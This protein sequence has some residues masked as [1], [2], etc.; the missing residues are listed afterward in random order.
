MPEAP[1]TKEQVEIAEKLRKAARDEYEITKEQL[2]NK[3]KLTAKD[4][5][6][7]QILRDQ[8]TEQDKI[9][10]AEKE[11]LKI[12]EDL[13]K[14]KN[15]TSDL[16]TQSLSIEK[17]L[18]KEILK[19]RYSAKVTMGFGKIRDNFGLKW[20]EQQQRGQ[21]AMTQILDTE[22]K[23]IDELEQG[24]ADE[25]IYGSPEAQKIARLGIKDIANDMESI[26]QGYV[27]Q[28]GYAQMIAK[29]KEMEKNQNLPDVQRE[30]A[31]EA[32]KRA[33]L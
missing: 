7:L 2:G 22:K 28:A 8:V 14:E 9:L 10:D 5:E 19:Q 11:R 29:Y 17:K 27:D 24:E 30:L 12:E 25:N 15:K 18:T 13:Q 23:L 3:T 21:V 20:L 16:M 6:R 33:K 26:S 4:K 1:H 32:L 31:K